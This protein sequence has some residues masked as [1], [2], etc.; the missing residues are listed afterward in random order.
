MRKVARWVLARKKPICAEGKNL[1]SEAKEAK[2]VL[3]SDP[4]PIPPWR[5][6][7]QRRK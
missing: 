3:W 7:R 1:E 4:D 5:F 2:R 6:R